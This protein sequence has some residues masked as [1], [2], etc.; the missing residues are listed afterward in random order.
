[1]KEI[2]LCS[3]CKKC[4]KIIRIGKKYLIKDDYGGQVELSKN[5]LMKLIDAIDFILNDKE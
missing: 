1:M 4:P 5:E 2:S 3:T